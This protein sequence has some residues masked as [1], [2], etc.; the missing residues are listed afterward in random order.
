MLISRILWFKKKLQNLNDAKIKCRENNIKVTHNTSIIKK[1]DFNMVVLLS[2]LLSFCFFI[3]YSF[4]SSVLVWI[5][6]GVRVSIR[7][8]FLSSLWKEQFWKG[9]AGGDEPE[10]LKKKVARKKRLRCIIHCWSRS[11]LLDKTARAKISRLLESNLQGF[12]LSF[13]LSTCKIYNQAMLPPVTPY[14]QPVRRFLNV[15][16]F[17]SFSITCH[18]TALILLECENMR[19]NGTYCLVVCFN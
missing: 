16:Y 9:A 4:Q 6:V 12:W 5:T 18:F 11:G 2:V 17:I 3:F 19:I 10:I 8:V 14:S 1:G 15:I 7:A 13:P